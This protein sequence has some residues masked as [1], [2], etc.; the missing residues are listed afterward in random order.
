MRTCNVNLLILLNFTVLLRALVTVISVQCFGRWFLIR[1]G[2]VPLVRISFICQGMRPTLPESRW[3]IWLKRTGPGARQG[4]H[5]LRPLPR[6]GPLDPFCWL[7]L[8]VLPRGLLVRA[9]WACGRDKRGGCIS[10]VDV[11]WATTQ[12]DL[13][14]GVCVCVCV[15]VWVGVWVCFSE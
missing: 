2:R 8:E 12:A 9:W 5:H 1:S 11:T 10:D 4:R 3:G 14:L 6:S 13:T 7:P 15:C